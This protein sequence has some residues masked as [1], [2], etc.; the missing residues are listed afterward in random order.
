MRFEYLFLGWANGI[1]CRRNVSYLI[2]A[3]I[4]QAR[5]IG[6]RQLTCEYF[7]F[8]ALSLENYGKYANDANNKNRINNYINDAINDPTRYFKRNFN[9]VRKASYEELKYKR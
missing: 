1:T 2:K 3:T 6:A 5:N 4:N 9:K 8:R 7:Y